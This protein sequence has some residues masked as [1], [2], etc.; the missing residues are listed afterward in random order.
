MGVAQR[1]SERSVR[2]ARSRAESEV[3][4][5]LDAA[6]A[7][8]RRGGMEALTVSEVLAEAELS[9]RA[10]YR[11]FAS[12]DELVLALFAHES[13]RATAQRTARLAAAGA[14]IDALHAWID[15]VLALG[16]EPRRAARTRVLLA[17]GDR[18][19]HDF[20]QELARILD[21]ELAPLIAILAA[22]HAAGAFPRAE[23][24]VDAHTIHSL[25]WSFTQARLEG[26]DLSIDDARAHVRRFVFPALGIADS[27]R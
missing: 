11:H 13:E 1:I 18:L 19:R 21:D 24:S 27:H 10:F 15:E 26:R 4:T 25:V 17:E 3:R 8:L 2:G 9:T 23:P 22:G 12:K 16:F 7:V 20:P 14:P 5:L 6:F